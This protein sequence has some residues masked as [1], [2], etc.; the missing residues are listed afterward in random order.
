[1]DASG[2]LVARPLDRDLAAGTYAA[3]WD[4]AGRNG[5]RA[6]AGVYFLS[7]EVPGAHQTRRIVLER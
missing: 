3:A 6:A 1:M 5:S 7:L 4:G 2:R